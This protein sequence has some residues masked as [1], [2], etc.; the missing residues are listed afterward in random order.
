MVQ[1]IQRILNFHHAETTTG[2]LY[3]KMQDLLQLVYQ[4]KCL[5]T[6]TQETVGRRRR[7]IGIGTRR[8]TLNRRCIKYCIKSSLEDKS[9]TPLPKYNV[10]QK[11]LAQDADGLLYHAIV[12]H[13]LNSIYHIITNK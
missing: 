5:L 3:K 9:N 4:T 11:V 12:C 10:Q 2:L 13:K 6:Q 8:I 1:A 7:R